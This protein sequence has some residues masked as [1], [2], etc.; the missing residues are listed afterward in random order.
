MNLI[1]NG[2]SARRGELAR[3]IRGP[4]LG[5]VRQPMGGRCGAMRAGL[6]ADT[7]PAAAYL[8]AGGGGDR[9]PRILVV[10][11]SDPTPRIFGRSH[12]LIP[13][14]Y[15]ICKRWPIAVATRVRPL[16]SLRNIAAK[17]PLDRDSQAKVR[18]DRGLALPATLFRDRNWLF[19]VAGR[20][21]GLRRVRVVG[22]YP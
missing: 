20:P 8:Q 6:A 10:V 14:A 5:R 17:L 4:T 13:F 1:L 11:G 12:A 19:T 18:P 7:A 2:P 16:I 15:W 21:F 3:T 22:R 9:R